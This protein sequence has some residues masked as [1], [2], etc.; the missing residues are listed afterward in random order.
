MIKCVQGA[1]DKRKEGASGNM[2]LDIVGGIGADQSSIVSG[3]LVN[4][5]KKKKKMLRGDQSSMYS[6]SVPPNPDYDDDEEGEDEDEEDDEYEDI[7]ER[8]STVY[9]GEQITTSAAIRIPLAMN[10]PAP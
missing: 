9:G 2:M 4:D 7:N 1:K 3:S 8:E 6:H 5:G 10:E